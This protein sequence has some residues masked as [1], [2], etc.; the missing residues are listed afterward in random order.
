MTKAHFDIIILK[1]V[2]EMKKIP[3]ARCR[4]WLEL[5]TRRG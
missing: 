4:E 5:N 2:I 1:K 3:Y